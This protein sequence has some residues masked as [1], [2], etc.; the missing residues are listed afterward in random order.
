MPSLVF[1]PRR[2]RAAVAVALLF[3]LA[4]AQAGCSDRIVLIPTPN[5]NLTPAGT[6]AFD[7]VPPP[8]RHPDVEL[9][10]AADRS[11]IRKTVFGIEY[12]SG[13]SGML[14]VGT[15]RVSFDPAV[16]WDELVKISTSNSSPGRRP[17][18]RVSGV[19]QIGVIAVP[20]T[21][22]EVRDGQ[23]VLTADAKAT[24]DKG[25]DAFRA[26]VAARLADAPRKDIYVF[27][28]GFNNS[29]NDALTRLAMVWHMA[30]R[31]GVAVAY[32]W[33]AGYG[34]LFGYAYDRE[35]GEFTISHLRRF[36]KAVAAVPEV[37]RIHLIAHSRG[38]DVAIGA[39]RELSIEARAKGLKTSEEYKLDDVVLAAPDVDS[40]VFEQRFAIEDLHLV[41]NRVT[42][43]LS[44]TDFALAVSKWL[45]G[46]GS[47]LGNL[48]PADFTPEFRAKVAQLRGFTLI[49]CNV[50]GYS[51][52]HDYA[53]V[54]PAV[55]S[56]LIL[57]LR[58]GKPP[59]AANG[60]PLGDSREGVWEIT[61]DYLKPRK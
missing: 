33:P 8:Q 39:L 47:R 56:D 6:A 7:A 26:A 21:Q 12:G 22:M 14:A 18:L 10:Y 40:G 5:L 1:V 55:V 37:G 16:S 60:R 35:S 46:G 25:Q 20:L 48:R 23:Y 58:D 54:H 27:V 45:F 57:L 17:A 19:D 42:V 2:T 59:G 4:G 38:T 61:N 44:R 15:A 13:R 53:F 31:P 52:S 30:G 28:H 24:I 3:C 9:L 49:D 36:L 11:A 29:F 32:G 50:S 51:G 34:G 41:A 43:Y